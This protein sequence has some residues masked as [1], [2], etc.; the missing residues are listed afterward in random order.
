MYNQCVLVRVVP[1]Y[2]T[3]PFTSMTL[4]SLV[5]PAKEAPFVAGGGAGLFAMALSRGVLVDGDVATG[6]ATA[7]GLERN[8]LV[9]PAE[10]LAC[11]LACRPYTLRPTLQERWNK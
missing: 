5:H 11:V 3:K 2:V 9:R 4:I 10:E 1:Y 6:G 7:A 8:D